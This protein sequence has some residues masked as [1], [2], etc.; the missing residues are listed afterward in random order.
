[1][2]PTQLQI[3][4]RMQ[5]LQGRTPS[6]SLFSATIQISSGCRSTIYHIKQRATECPHNSTANTTTIDHLRSHH[7]QIVTLM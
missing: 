5:T 3:L 4:A 1:M 7:P 6:T 2:L